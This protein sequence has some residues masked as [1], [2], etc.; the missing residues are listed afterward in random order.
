MV[1]LIGASLQFGQRSEGTLQVASSKD[2]LEI[3]MTGAAPLKDRG[4]PMQ[5]LPTSQHVT[6]LEPT[7]AP[8]ADRIAGGI[9]SS[10]GKLNT[11]D[12]SIL[13]NA[14]ISLLRWSLC[15]CHF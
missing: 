7:L 14:C 4:V 2:V 10:L 12:S 11:I 8:V 5:L 15:C 3:L 1:A 6:T 9:C 13:I